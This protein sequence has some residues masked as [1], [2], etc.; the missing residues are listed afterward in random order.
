MPS[1][2]DG[3]HHDPGPAHYHG[4]YT[5]SN[6]GFDHNLVGRLSTKEQPRAYS[7]GKAER[8]GAFAGGEALGPGPGEYDPVEYE[9]TNP[10]GRGRGEFLQDPLLERNESMQA[11]LARLG[12]DP[13]GPG[14]YDNQL[15]LRGLDYASTHPRSS[16]CM[17]VLRQR[18]YEGAGREAQDTTP[19]PHEY[20]VGGLSD[21]PVLTNT[22]P[23]HLKGGAFGSE[24]RVTG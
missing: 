13:V 18:Y 20:D 10:G 11:R 21:V 22:G 7:V 1:W 8:W 4:D 17:A 24:P 19:G 3:K 23:V 16:M 5:T 12:L 9:W 15:L 6:I 14:S 2:G